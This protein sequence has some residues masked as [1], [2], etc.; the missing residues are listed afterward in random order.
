MN[1]LNNRP[2]WLTC[3]GIVLFC[4]YVGKVSIQKLVTSEL[5]DLNA[6]PLPEDDEQPYAEHIENVLIQEYH[7]SAV[8]MLKG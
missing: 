2:N 6:L 1:N 7:M 5:T 8:D 4:F 3:W